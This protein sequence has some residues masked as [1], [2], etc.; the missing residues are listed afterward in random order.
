MNAHLDFSGTAISSLITHHVGNKLHENSKLTLSN[1]ASTLTENETLEHLFTYFLSQFKPEDFQNFTHSIELDLNEVYATAKKIFSDR[2]SFIGESQNLAKLLYEYADHPQIKS[3]ELNVVYFEGVQINDEVTDAIGLFKS[4]SNIPFL[5]MKEQTSGYLI[6]HKY[7]FELKGIDKACLIL[8][9]D[10]HLGYSVLVIDKKNKIDAQYWVN[11][12][13]RLKP[14]LDDY[15]H[16]KAFLSVTKDFVTNELPEHHQVNKADQIHLL[17][18]TMDYFK[19][20]EK[21]DKADFER[22]VF[23]DDKVINSFRSFEDEIKEVQVS[24]SSFDISDKAVKKQARI[25]KSVLKLD[26]NFHVYIHGNRE[27]IER[28]MENDGRKY[29]KIYYEEES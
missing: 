14:S 29:Y 23:Q 18:R 15:N 1:E 26:K 22:E 17:N 21:F 10:Q 8:N 13:L 7:G 24:R 16:T 12:F 19:G 5:Q 4:E 6:D 28:G 2:S 3:G 11:K 27:L 20:N 9:T 25:Y